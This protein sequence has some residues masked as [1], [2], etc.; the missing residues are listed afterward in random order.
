M[1]S[2][3]A[4]PTP[5]PTPQTAQ[6]PQAPSPEVP[7][8]RNERVGSVATGLFG[9]DAG[10]SR[11]VIVLATS[12]CYQQNEIGEREVSW[13]ALEAPAKSGHL[14]GQAKGARLAP[15]IPGLVA[16]E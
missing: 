5:F 3:T 1:R 15:A 12:R 9:D 7:L 16:G 13:W 4:T 10:E 14:A 6:S 8:A 2:G 11:S